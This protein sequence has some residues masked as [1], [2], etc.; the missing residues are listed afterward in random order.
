MNSS[1][2]RFH[3][4]HGTLIQILEDGRVAR[5]VDSQY[6]GVVFGEQPISIGNMFQVKILEEDKTWVG[7]LVRVYASADIF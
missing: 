4:K 1:Y 7:T 6:N 3:Q 5:R 2:G